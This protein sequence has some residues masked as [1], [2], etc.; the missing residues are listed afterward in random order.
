MRG[1]A[2]AVIVDQG[3]LTDVGRVACEGRQAGRGV[4]VIPNRSTLSEVARTAVDTRAL[5]LARKG[6]ETLMEMDAG[7]TEAAHVRFEE[8]GDVWITS[9]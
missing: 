4:L 2:L 8:I 3:A 5:N 7:S 6:V 9:H 1:P